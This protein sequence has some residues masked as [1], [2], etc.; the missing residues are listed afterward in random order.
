MMIALI[1]NIVTGRAIAMRGILIAA[2]LQRWTALKG[3][4]TESNLATLPVAQGFS[5]AYLPGC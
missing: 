5:P 4:A 2:L 3:C 1:M